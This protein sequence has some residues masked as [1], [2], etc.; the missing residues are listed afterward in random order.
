MVYG[1]STITA[2]LKSVKKV[3]N[4]QKEAISMLGLTQA[5]SIFTTN[6]IKISQDVQTVVQKGNQIDVKSDQAYEKLEAISKQIKE[7]INKTK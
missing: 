5:D 1:N 4:T 3:K 7:I 2:Y 6:L